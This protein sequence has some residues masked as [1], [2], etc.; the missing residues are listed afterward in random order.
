MIQSQHPPKLPFDLWFP[1][2]ED[3]LIGFKGDIVS[4]WRC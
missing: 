1:S 4:C 2:R 3:L